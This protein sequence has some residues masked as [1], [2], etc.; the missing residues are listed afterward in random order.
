TEDHDLEEIN[1]T[2]IGGKTIT[3]ETT[4]PTATGRLSTANIHEA[5][6]AYCNILGLSEHS[7]RLSD[8]V[9]KAYLEHATLAAATRF[10]VN[11]LF[12][13]YGLVILDADHPA[14][15]KVFAPVMERDILEQ[16]SYR[17]ISRSTHSLQER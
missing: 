1:H 14:L 17:E 5:V 4:C 6:R 11:A 10:L 3:W 9:E 2:S 13:E 8:L 15:K 12:S 16:N 7:R